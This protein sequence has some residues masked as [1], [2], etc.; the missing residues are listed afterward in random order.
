[1]MKNITIEA[2]E[3]VKVSKTAKRIKNLSERF[4][5]IPVSGG[6]DERGKRVMRYEIP[7]PHMKYLNDTIDDDTAVLEIPEYHT[8]EFLELVTLSGGFTS[9]DIIDLLERVRAYEKADLELRQV[10]LNPIV[11][12]KSESGIENDENITNLI[13]KEKDIAVFTSIDELKEAQ[14]NEIVKDMTAVELKSDPSFQCILRVLPDGHIYA[15]RPYNSEKYV[16][17]K[18]SNDDLYLWNKSE[19]EYF[20]QHW[21]NEVKSFSK[22]HLDKLDNRTRVNYTEVYM[23]MKDKYE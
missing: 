21:L 3:L 13:E 11:E 18:Q 7:A 1:M 17:S 2:E 8:L 9:N 20:H 5:V 6:R 4:G 10:V 12:A 16:V 22:E 19:L 23:K 15:V 14:R